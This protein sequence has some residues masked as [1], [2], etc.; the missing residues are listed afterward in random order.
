MP[1]LFKVQIGMPAAFAEAPA[2]K[3]GQADENAVWIVL[4]DVSLIHDAE[5]R[6]TYLA[7]KAKG[8]LL[9]GCIS[10]KARAACSGDQPLTGEPAAKVSEAL[11]G[12]PAQLHESSSSRLI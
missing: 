10:E 3:A 2:V 9:T 7:V 1:G 11:A 6:S 12:S 4:F 8:A 5:E